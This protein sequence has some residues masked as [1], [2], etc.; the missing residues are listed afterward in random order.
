MFEGPQV[1]KGMLTKEFTESWKASVR[2]CHLV[3]LSVE[4]LTGR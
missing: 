2:K 3:D 4:E 1:Y